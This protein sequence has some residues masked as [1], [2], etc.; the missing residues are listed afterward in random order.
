[1]STMS[2]KII[3]GYYYMSDR[4]TLYLLINSIEYFKDGVS[5]H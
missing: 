4:L 2:T 5:C 1:M 3:H